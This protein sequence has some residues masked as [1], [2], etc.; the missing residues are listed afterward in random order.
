MNEQLVK[1]AEQISQLRHDPSRVV[2]EVTFWKDHDK[3][4][5][6]CKKRYTLIEIQSKNIKLPKGVKKGTRMSYR[7]ISGTIFQEALR[8]W[9]EAK[10]SKE[11]EE[12]AKPEESCGAKSDGRTAPEVQG[13]RKKRKSTNNGTSKVQGAQE[14]NPKDNTK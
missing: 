4:E 14:C 8:I 7:I 13:T 11:G 3:K 10:N 12:H 9:N 1:A 5:E 2:V 6:L